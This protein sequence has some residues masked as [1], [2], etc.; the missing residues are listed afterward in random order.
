MVYSEDLA[1]RIR[2]ALSPRTPFDE[3]KMF[4]GIAFMVN[5]HMALGVTRDDLMVRVGKDGMGAALERG[6]AVMEM[7]GR[8]MTGMILVDGGR[9][10]DPDE[11]DAWVATAVEH[12]L[13]D[14][15]KAKKPRKS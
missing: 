2:A 1:D 7:G 13:A 6:G 15:A 4:G 12:A 3:R 10:A 5:T 11:L 14:P 8:P 9:V